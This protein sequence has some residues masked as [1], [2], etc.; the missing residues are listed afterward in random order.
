MINERV[1]VEMKDG[2]RVTGVLVATDDVNLS[3][4][5]GQSTVKFERSAIASIRLARKV[6]PQHS[7]EKT[8]STSNSQPSD[9]RSID[10]VTNGETMARMN[11]AWFSG[12][13]SFF[14]FQ[15]AEVG[16]AEVELV[17]FGIAGA[18]FNVGFG[19][20]SG[21]MLAGARF[22]LLADVP[23]RGDI[24]FLVRVVGR[25]EFVVTSG[26]AR[27]F[28][29]MEVGG[30]NTPVYSRSYGTLHT[31]ISGGY[32]LFVGKNFSVDPYLEVGA[33]YLP[34]YEGKGVSVRLGFLMSGWS[35][36]R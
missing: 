13:V 26:N 16:S 22:G 32:H 25:L 33:Q 6:P 23:E 27:P 7:S 36:N 18:P 10:D 29:A 30:F 28:V 14:S 15:H 9:D 31:G 20:Q 34:E 11:G 1:L 8:S 5:K 12:D 19:Y 3:M 24:D 4:K 21:H 35:W 2:T 17:N